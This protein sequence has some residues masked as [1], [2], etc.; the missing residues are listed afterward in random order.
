MACQG[1]LRSMQIQMLSKAR[2]QMCSAG[3]CCLVL[4]C[5][6]ALPCKLHATLAYVFA[7]GA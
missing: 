5:H 4:L 7:D 1:A 6:A 3:L 2:W